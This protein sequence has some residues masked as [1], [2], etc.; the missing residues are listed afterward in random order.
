MATK[1]KKSSKKQ[2][3]AESEAVGLAQAN[4]E[5]YRQYAEGLFALD[6]K[7]KVVQYRID[8]IMYTSEKLPASRGLE[9]WPVANRI[10]A[11]VFASGQI[12]IETVTRALGRPSD[13]M[14]ALQPI[15]KDLVSC[16]Q[17]G[18]IRGEIGE[19]D[20][21]VAPYFDQH[22]AGEYDH[23]LR[24]CFFAMLHNFAGPTL[25]VR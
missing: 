10:I 7:R 11:L 12:S 15:M 8:G 22:F 16:I 13:V 20:G 23:L 4:A 19:S 17:C 2:T 3:A 18:K 1:K 14:G 24:V 5:Q 25:G 21:P 6:F 9:V